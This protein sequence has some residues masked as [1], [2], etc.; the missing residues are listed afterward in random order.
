LEGVGL[1]IQHL[2]FNIFPELEIGFVRNLENFTEFAR[3]PPQLLRAAP[4]EG[5]R[6]GHAKNRSFV[7][8][9]K[10]AI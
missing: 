9:R 10:R 2:Q 4:V 6:N 7:M 1:P 8:G 3:A 5:R